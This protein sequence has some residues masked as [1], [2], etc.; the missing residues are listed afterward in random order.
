[1]TVA[2]TAATVSPWTTTTAT[3]TV[4]NR[5]KAPVIVRRVV[6]HAGSLRRPL[7]APR[8]SF[9]VKGQ[10]RRRTL[11]LHGKLQVEHFGLVAVARAP[12][13]PRWVWTGADRIATVLVLRRGEQRSWRARFRARY[14]AGPRLTAE[15]DVVAAGSRAVPLFALASAPRRVDHSAKRRNQPVRRGPRWVTAEEVF[16]TYRRSATPAKA[17]L[18]NKIGR[19]TVP[20]QLPLP[21][22]ANATL[23]SALARS[24]PVTLRAVAPLKVRRVKPVDIGRARAV[25]KVPTGSYTRALKAGR[26]LLHDAR[27]GRTC[28][29]DARGRKTVV[30]GNALALA[31]ALNDGTT[32]EVTLFAFNRHRDPGGH[33][34]YFA[35][36]GFKA[37]T[38]GPHKGMVYSGKVRLTGAALPRFLRL[39]QRRGLALRGDLGPAAPIGRRRRR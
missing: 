14:E 4:K 9:A 25:C 26:R 32:A 11:R 7:L 21:I 19:V 6:V 2:P 24:R 16:L 10:R 35:R 39:L 12:A 29:V 22:Y 30:A 20:R 28:L 8:T 5:G 15:V 31:D 1:V 3:V 13:P 23:A 34:R 33:V 18:V 37:R 36:R 38:V 17:A 27:R